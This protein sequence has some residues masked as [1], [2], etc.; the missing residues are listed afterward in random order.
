MCRGRVGLE[1]LVAD[2]LIDR[3]VPSGQGLFNAA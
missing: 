3:P 2:Q 1:E